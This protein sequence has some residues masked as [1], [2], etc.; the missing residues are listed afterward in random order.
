MF[1]RKM[2]R[3]KFVVCFF[4]CLMQ[5]DWITKAFKWVEI[6]TI[7]I[8]SVVNYCVWTFKNFHNK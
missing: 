7:N 1:G 8:S 3:Q 5:R 4:V 6:S 2:F